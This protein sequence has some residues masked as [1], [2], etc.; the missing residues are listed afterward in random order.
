MTGIRIEEQWFG[1]KRSPLLDFLASKIS[2]QFHHQGLPRITLSGASKL[3]CSR[4]RSSTVCSRR[5]P[6]L[7]TAVLISSASF[8]TSC[9]RQG[10]QVF[11]ANL[12]QQC[13]MIMMLF[14]AVLISS[15]FAPPPPVHGRYY[16][17]WQLDSGS[18][19]WCI[20]RT[21]RCWNCRVDFLAIDAAKRRCKSNSGW[22]RQLECGAA[23]IAGAP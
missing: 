5:A 9:W 14:I 4:M 18:R 6:M 22:A 20:W 17:H 7:S 2:M 10:F 13:K 3:I 23:K 11:T 12:R 1:V 19:M 8:A 15:G 21:G 16:K